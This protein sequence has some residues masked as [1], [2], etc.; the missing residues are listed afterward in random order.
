M[1][2]TWI[3][4]V[5]V[6]VTLSVIIGISSKKE[7]EIMIKDITVSELKTMLNQ[8]YQFVDI[9]TKEE[10]S[11]VAGPKHINGFMNI[12][13]YEFQSNT[14]L[15][16]SLDKNKPVVIICNSGNRSRAAKS[17]FQDLGF[18][19]IYNVLGGMQAWVQ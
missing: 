9:R 17:I 8:N 7:E 6:I 14:D 16:S 2:K 5:V 1:K 13:Y 18:K 12:D 19:E 11:G 10:Y 3:L 15:L 4:V